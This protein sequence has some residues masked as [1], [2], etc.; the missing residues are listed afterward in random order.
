MKYSF[1]CEGQQIFNLDC[2]TEM[3]DIVSEGPGKKYWKTPKKYLIIDFLFAAIKNKI[4]Y[5][6]VN[7]FRWHLWYNGCAS[8][9]TNINPY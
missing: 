1:S 3:V 2:E 5:L 9:P 7:Y 8:Q 4:F 6:C